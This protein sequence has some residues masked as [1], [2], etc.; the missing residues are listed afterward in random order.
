MDEMCTIMSNIHQYVPKATQ[1]VLHQGEHRAVIEEFYHGILFGGDQLTV[2][3]SRGAQSARSN[4]DNPVEWLEGLIPVAEDWHT[5]LT[6]MRVC[7]LHVVN[8]VD[9]IKVSYWM[10][11]YLTLLG[12]LCF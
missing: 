5:R 10:G 4:E 9:V 11:R 6:I 2:C 8:L 12:K 1:Q 7:M 3:R